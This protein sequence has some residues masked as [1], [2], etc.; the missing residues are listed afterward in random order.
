MPRQQLPPQIKKITLKNGKVRYHVKENGRVDPITK[1][2]PKLDKRFDTAQQARD[3]LRDFQYQTARGTYVMR[4]TLTVEQACAN[5]LAGRHGLRKPAKASLLC[6]LLTPGPRR[7]AIGRE[8]QLWAEA[9]PGA[10]TNRPTAANAAFQI[11]IMC[12]SCL[13]NAVGQRAGLAS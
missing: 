10:A 13:D 3:A 5:W 11:F 2:R 6:G 1:Q 12:I 8:G 4:S 7:D 9:M